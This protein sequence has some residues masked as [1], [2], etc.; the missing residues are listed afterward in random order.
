MREI[1]LSTGI[2][3]YEDTGGDGPVIV[4]LHG[5]LMDSSLWAGV[6]DELSAE[7][8]CVAPTLPMGAHGHGMR[9]DT[10]LS[11]P[12]IAGWWWNSSTALTC[13]I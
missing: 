4:L 10:D 8:R 5:L 7:F 3:E 9:A 1:E 2:I 12:G 6:L 13:T 11:L